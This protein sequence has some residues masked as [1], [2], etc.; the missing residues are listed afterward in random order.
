MTTDDIAKLRD[1]CVLQMAKVMA[2]YQHIE[3]NLDKLIDQKYEVIKLLVGD[4]AIIKRGRKGKTLGS[5]VSEFKTITDNEILIS[6]LEALTKSRNEVAH[7]EFAIVTSL[8]DPIMLKQKH[9]EFILLEDKTQEVL[10]QHLSEFASSMSLEIDS[11][12]TEK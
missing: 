9:F 8:T 11:K 3:S 10:E 7:K 4:K 12:N 2:V 1:Q 5:L 6:K